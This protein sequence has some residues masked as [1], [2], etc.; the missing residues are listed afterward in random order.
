MILVGDRRAED[1][2]DA[3]AGALHDVAVVAA[4]RVDHQLERGIDD[5]AGLLGIEVLLQLSRTLDIRE[6][7]RHRL[8]L[9]FEIFRGGRVGYSN[10]RVVRFL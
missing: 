5:C 2:E 4:D 1:R 3:V 8:P 6:Q 7:R 10:R 9:A